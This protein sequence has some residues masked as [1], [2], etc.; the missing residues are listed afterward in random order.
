MNSNPSWT[1]F[2]NILPHDKIM[3]NEHEVAE[4]IRQSVKTL[5]AHRY[6]GKGLPYTKI[7]RNVRYKLTTVLAYLESLPTLNST[8]QIVEE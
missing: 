8:S 3:L 6:T 1:N 7:G 2:Q 5:R 4:L